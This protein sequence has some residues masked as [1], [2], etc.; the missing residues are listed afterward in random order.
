ML[1]DVGSFPYNVVLV[2]HILAV[3]VAFAPAFVWPVV[4]V[5]MR[6][7]GGGTLPAEVSRHIAPQNM[8][9]HGPALIAAGLFGII[10]VL[11]SGEVYE[12]SQAWISIAFV[13]WF[14]MLGVLFLGA[15]PAER[16]AAEA[17]DG[18]A[19]VAKINMFG[20]ILHL[21]LLLMVIVMVWKP[22]F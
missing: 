3:L 8:R 4:R 12:F 6:K 19:A 10:G 5:A 17:A 21:L 18:Q 9:V 22:G 16:A 15:I 7:Q 14:L 1:A 13:L 11:L 20:G 2:L